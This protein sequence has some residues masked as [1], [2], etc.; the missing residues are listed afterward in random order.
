MPQI[1][2]KSARALFAEA[3]H[4]AL[5]RA[6]NGQALRLSP[7]ASKDEAKDEA[8]IYLYDAIGGWFGIAASEFV[9]ELNGIKAK[10]IHLRVNSP[11]GSVFD[12]EA[13]QTAIQQH[14]AK[15]IAH[16]DGIAA[17]AATYIATAADEIEASDGAFWMIHNAWG[18]AIGDSAEMRSYADMLDKLSANIA[19]DYQ[20]KTGKS[21]E[22][23]KEWMDAETWFSAAE[24]LEAGFV[25]RIYPEKSENSGDSEGK[26]SDSPEKASDTAK[27]EAVNGDGGKAARARALALL[28][29]GS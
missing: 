25:D 10:T 4:A 6:K 24:A 23:V 15:V 18:V 8:T 1:E 20:R 7:P 3:E 28:E 27:S 11:G 2:K 9:G 21:A 5:D 13:I 19:K 26:D 14:P 29:V 22:Q 12:A 16:I 17:S